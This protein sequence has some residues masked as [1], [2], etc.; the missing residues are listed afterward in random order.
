MPP[1][2]WTS[3]VIL[4]LSPLPE[5]NLVRT[6][7]PFNGR[8]TTVWAF[9]QEPV[10][11]AEPGEDKAALAL[12][13]CIDVIGL[14]SYVLAPLSTFAG[15]RYEVVNDVPLA[16]ASKWLVQLAIGQHANSNRQPQPAHSENPITTCV[17][18]VEEAITVSTP[19]TGRE[20]N[21]LLFQFV[22]GLLAVEKSRGEPL[23]EAEKT[24]AF[25]QWLR[26]ASGFL[27]HGKRHYLT[28]YRNA[29]ECAET[30]LGACIGEVWERARQGPLP[31]EA[32]EFRP[33]KQRLLV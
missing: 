8:P 25:E 30:P 10:V 4:S 28:K 11:P 21:F 29:W 12:G 1:S 3:T 15:G 26:A 13:Q 2:G 20:N 14:G 27:R 9:R 22:R 33:R 6:F 18:N 31:P 32:K 23:S 19:K 17:Q 24:E 16:L 7:E 5:A